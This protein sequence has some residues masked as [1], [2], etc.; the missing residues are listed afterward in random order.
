MQVRVDEGLPHPP[1]L[2]DDV[3][4]LGERGGFQF[5]GVGHQVLWPWG[6][7]GPQRDDVLRALVFTEL[8]RRAGRY[9]LCTGA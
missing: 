8:V 6:E 1:V 7:S 5:C 4:H 3:H 2:G 9:R